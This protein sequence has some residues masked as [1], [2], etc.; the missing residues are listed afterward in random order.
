MATNLSKYVCGEAIYR[1][2]SRSAEGGVT[3]ARTKVKINGQG[4]KHSFSIGVSNLKYQMSHIMRK[5]VF[6]GLQPG[7]TQTKLF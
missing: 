5:S 3:A 1:W 4:G 2:K 7:K 6:S